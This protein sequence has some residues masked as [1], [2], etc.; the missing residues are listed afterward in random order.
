[1]GM[2]LPTYLIYDA[3]VGMDHGTGMYLK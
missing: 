1:M 3:F 2:I